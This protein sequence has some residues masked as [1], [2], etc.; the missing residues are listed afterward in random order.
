[1]LEVLQRELHLLGR[2]N[3]AT[4]LVSRYRF[5]AFPVGDRA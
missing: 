3:P 1:M 5:G 2:Y 4:Q